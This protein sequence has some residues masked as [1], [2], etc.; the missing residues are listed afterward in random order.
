MRHYLD[1][2][3][4]VFKAACIDIRENLFRPINNI[5]VIFGLAEEKSIAERIDDVRKQE[6]AQEKSE[7][8]HS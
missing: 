4:I 1:E 3:K 8:H 5:K 2:L 7:N 6:Q